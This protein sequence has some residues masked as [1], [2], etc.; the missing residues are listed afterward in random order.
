MTLIYEHLSDTIQPI[1]ELGKE[2]EIE[3]LIGLKLEIPRWGWRRT[4]TRQSP[5]G[6]GEVELCSFETG[7]LKLMYDEGGA[8]ARTEPQKG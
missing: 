7:L 1:T 3:Q 8:K 5:R 6:T 2:A 4:E